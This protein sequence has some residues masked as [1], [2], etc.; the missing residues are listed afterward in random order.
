MASVLVPTSI[1]ISENQT[2]DV[3]GSSTTSVVENSDIFLDLLLD[4]EH[5]Q[6]IS[7][8]IAQ[9][10]EIKYEKLSRSVMLREDTSSGCGGK[11]WEAADV[12]CKYFIWKYHAS[13]GKAYCN[14]NIVEL[15]SGTG[16][17]GLV[18]GVLCSPNGVKEIVITDQL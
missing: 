11:T 18:L 9:I 3:I 12:I 15:G 17:V 6:V 4:Q 10:S 7:S 5:G 1:L 13:H 16:V 14:K 8:T 2:L